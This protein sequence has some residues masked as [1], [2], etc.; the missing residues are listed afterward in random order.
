MRWYRRLPRRN[1]LLVYLV[2]SV[3]A[4][5]SDGGPDSAES[6][7]CRLNSDCPL[8]QYCRNSACVSGCQSQSD[9]ASGEN[10]D[11]GTCRKAASGN[12]AS[13][14]R[15]SDGTSSVSGGSGGSDDAC[16]PDCTER[17]CGEDPDCG[18]SCGECS[19]GEACEDGACIDPTCDSD[20]SAVEC[21]P[22]PVC[23][24]SC[25]DCGSSEACLDGS[26]VDNECEP[27][28]DERECGPDPACGISCGDCQSGTTCENGV[29][30]GGLLEWVSTAAGQGSSRV[31][32]VDVGDD[33]NLA[34]V[35]RFRDSVIFGPG[36]VNQ[37]TLVAQASNDGFVAAYRGD[38]TLLWVRQAASAGRHDV[39]DVVLF[40]DGTVLAT[41]SYDSGGTLNSGESD[42]LVLPSA[43]GGYVAHYLPDGE[44]SWVRS[45]TGSTVDPFALV[46]L[47]N[48]S[49]IVGGVFTGNATFGGGE[50]SEKSFDS[51]GQGDAWLARLDADGSLLWVVRAGGT[52]GDGVQDLAVD[53]SSIYVAGG[54]SGPALFGEGEPSQTQLIP[55]GSGTGFIARYALDGTLHWATMVDSTDT[56]VVNAVT[57]FPDGSAGVLGA[58]SGRVTFGAGT[59][60]EIEFESPEIAKPFVARYSDAGVPLWVEV[61]DGDTNFQAGGLTVSSGSDILA[62]SSF[63]ESILFDPTGGHSWS[64]D[65]A[66]YQDLYVA[67]YDSNGAFLWARQ[68]GGVDTTMNV[69]DIDAVQGGAVVIAGEYNGSPTFGINEPLETT[70]DYASSR[71]F[72]ARLGP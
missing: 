36:E 41:G 18:V 22:D 49:S 47:P 70:L 66:G 32:A 44:L 21:G 43:Y 27:E 58:G 2:F 28:C 51:Y 25:G 62:L 15:S 4:A 34:A 42:E 11:A 3:A 50:S 10:C 6:A 20:C 69:A 63:Q 14:G 30:A 26:C 67:R 55:S 7:E 16:E 60:D 61:A 54:I 5:C 29:C 19:P 46:A 57:V 8:E 48:G 12:V 13:G 59:N 31:W 17:A 68:A 45:F 53:G 72:I 33:G 56:V 52:E 71:M 1:S 65:A 40:G 37:A 24:T 9:C 38:G 39:A 23:G 64:L 35:G